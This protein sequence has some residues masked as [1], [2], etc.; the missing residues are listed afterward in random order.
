MKNLGIRSIIVKKFRPTSSKSKVESRENV[1]KRDFSTSNINQ[2]WVT[3]I[4]YIYT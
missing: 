2:K 4:T 3:D 1:L